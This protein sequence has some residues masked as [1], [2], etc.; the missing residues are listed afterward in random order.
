MEGPVLQSRVVTRIGKLSGTVMNASA[1]SIVTSKI[2]LLLQTGQLA[3]ADEPAPDGGTDR[4]LRLPDTAAARLRTRGTRD[5]T[6]IP[7]S[8]FRLLA[9]Q[10][11]A[12]LCCLNGCEQH[13]RAIMA[14]YR[15]TRMN[16]KFRE[17]ILGIL[18]N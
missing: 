13:L 14:F 2:E 15:I 7:A 4:T 11:R 18:R 8:E 1:R 10:L 17:F 6:E 9:E 3:A 16:K 5:W 12:H